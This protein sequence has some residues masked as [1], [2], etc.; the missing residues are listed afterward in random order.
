MTYAFLDTSILMQYKV[1]EGMPWGDIIGDNDYQFVVPQKV[2]DEIDRHKDGVK[3]RLRKRA[4]L[5]GN[6]LGKYLEGKKPTSLDIKFC[7]NPT[8]SSTSRCDF[9]ASSADEYIV[10]SAYEYNS[11]G[12]RKVIVSADLG[13]KFRASKVGIA[14]I[15]P[16][17]SIRLSEEKTEEEKKILELEKRLATYENACAKPVLLFSQGEAELRYDKVEKPDLSNLETE[18]RQELEQKYPFKT[19]S[20]VYYANIFEQMAAMQNPILTKEDYERYNSMLPQF[21]DTETR[22]KC[23]SE[24]AEFINSNDSASF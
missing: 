4:R 22:Y 23:L 11:E 17:V 1:F 5:V 13:M 15:M 10:F 21:Y 6:H 2:L 14:V 20:E 12:N 19:Y 7:Q 9:D 16:D 18:I 3:E 8:S 24:V